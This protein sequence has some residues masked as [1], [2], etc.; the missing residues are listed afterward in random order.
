MS[1]LTPR[2]FV[3]SSTSTLF[4]AVACLL[5]GTDRWQLSHH[6][7]DES[8]SVST[9]SQMH[10][11]SGGPSEYSVYTIHSRYFSNIQFYR[12]VIFVSYALSLAISAIYNC[13]V[14]Q[15][16]GV[17][18]HKQCVGQGWEASLVIVTW[19]MDIWDDNDISR[20]LSQKSDMVPSCSITV[21][22]FKT[23]KCFHA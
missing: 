9:S 11:N 10:R 22:L 21:S 23:Y 5:L 14:S 15:T 2:K 4:S 18:R 16:N 7:R 13:T 3:D 8:L 1:P 20:Q 6:H 12:N 17:T 19:D